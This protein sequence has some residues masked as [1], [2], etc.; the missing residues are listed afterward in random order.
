MVDL[1]MKVFGKFTFS[2]VIGETPPL[3]S[4]IRKQLEDELRD[5]IKELQNKSRVELEETLQRQNAIRRELNRLTGAMALSQE[6]I[7]LFLESITNYIGVIE[8][9]LKSIQ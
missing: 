5:A 2:E 9:R 3:S 8:S 6:K 7:N 4:E 1:G